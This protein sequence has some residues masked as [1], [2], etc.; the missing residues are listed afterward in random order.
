MID[1]R[2]IFDQPLKTDL[3]TYDIIRKIESSQEDDYTTGCLLYCSYLKN[4]V[5]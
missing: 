1:G 3:R 4:A 2:I 5:I